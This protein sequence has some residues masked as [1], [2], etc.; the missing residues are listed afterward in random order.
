MNNSEIIFFSIFLVLILSILMI[1]LGLFNKKSHVIAFKEALIWSLVYIGISLVFYGFIH[2]K[3]DVIHGIKSKED[4]QQKIEKYSHPIEIESLSFEEAVKVYKKNLALE[5]I[6]GYLIEKS[7]SVDNIFVM[8][9]IFFAFG[10]KEIYYKKVLFWGILGAL[11]MRFIFIFSAAALI[12]KFNWVL[13]LFGGLL[14][15]TGIRMF[16]TRNKED[17]IDVEHHPVVKFA[18]K[19]FAVYPRYVRH[20]FFVSKNHKTFI[21]PLFIVLLVIEF[22]DVIFAVDSIPAIFSVT[23]DPYVVFFSNVFA[24]LGLRALFFLVINVIHIFHYLKVGLS[25]L[26]TFI[27]VKMIFHDY[28]ESLGFT[29]TISLWIILGILT[30]SILSSLMFP[31]EAKPKATF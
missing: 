21:T 29:T 10:V 6:T 2:F 23:K 26:L 14:I 25:V 24:I 30:V 12:Q 17:E 19:R 16:I 15:Y 4:I 11:V 8:V 18:S 27:G 5:Y 28:L 9:L 31:K 13:Y 1:D 20:H 22:S 3:G 7:L